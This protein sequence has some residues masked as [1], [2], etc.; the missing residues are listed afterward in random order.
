ML[1]GIAAAAA[2]PI[3]LAAPAAGAAVSAPSA[4]GAHAQPLCVPDP[5]TGTCN[6]PRVPGKPWFTQGANIR[7]ATN[8]GPAPVGALPFG[9]STTV[10]CYA[11]GQS[12]SSLV[13]ANDRFWDFVDFN[14]HEGFISD[15]VL[16]TGGDITTQVRQCVF[17]N[18]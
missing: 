11:T 9:V 1:A 6:P 8:T 2:A 5:N 3:G 4:P 14:G 17:G 16:N 18:A 12:V 7:P 10:F 13:I 15:A